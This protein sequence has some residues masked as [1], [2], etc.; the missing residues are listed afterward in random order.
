MSYTFTINTP[1]APPAGKALTTMQVGDIAKVVSSDHKGAVIL[2]TATGFVSLSNPSNKL[3]R[4]SL[5]TARV[6]FY[7]KGS[8]ATLKVG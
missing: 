4:L 2:K 5:Y 1:S 6:E 7:P 8:S 3:A